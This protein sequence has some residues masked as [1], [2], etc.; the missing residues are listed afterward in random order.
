MCS[1]KQKPNI[2][3][4]MAD[5]CI[6][7]L[8]GAYGHKVVKT[9]NLDKLVQ[10]GVRFDSAYTPCPICAPA[11]A[12]MMTGKYISNHK[13]TDNAAPLSCAEPTFCHYLNNE[14]YD[15]VLSGKMHF[16]GPDQLHGFAKRLVTN[17]Y[18]ADFEW[19]P[20]R[21]VLKDYAPVHANPI[22][23]DYVTA[24]VRQS[25]MQFEYDE[26]AQFRALQYIY[27]RRMQVGGTLQKPPKERDPKPFFLCVSFNHP[28]EP[29][30]PSQQLWDLYENEEIEIPEF[31]DNMEETYSTMD[32]WLN[33]FHGVHRV[34][35]K[36][37]EAL[38]NMR[39]AYYALV[40]YADKKVGELVKALE[41]SGL[42]DNTIIIFTSDHGDM[43][44]EKGMV[45]KR[46]LDWI[47]RNG[48]EDNWFLH[49][50]FWDVHWPYRTPDGFGN[51]FEDAPIPSWLTEE[52]RQKHWNEPGLKSAQD[53][54][55]FHTKF[56][57]YRKTPV[58]ASSMEEVRKMFDGYDTSIRYVDTHIGYILDTL[59]KQGIL[60]DTAVIVSADHGE[61]L[62]ELNIY[63]A[64]RFGDYMS[65]R[66]PLIV[67]W[68]GITTDKGMRIDKAFHYHFDFAATV[69]ELMGGTVPENWDGVSFADAFGK[70]EEKGRD[71]LVI[72]AGAGGLSRSIR[73]DNY[74]CIRLYHDCYQCLPEIMLFDVKNDPH[75]LRDL[76]DERPDLVGR[77]MILLD[78]WYGRMMHTATYPHDPFW[79]VIVEGG[80]QDSRGWIHGYIER[81]KETG[82]R[83]WVERIIEK[84]PR[85]YN[86]TKNISSVMKHAY[87][88]V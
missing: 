79:D 84:Y 60:E 33:T 63:A 1:S 34:D 51:P 44:G 83:Q 10:N 49:V 75:E 45:Q 7:F 21:E 86:P 30:H 42:R 73:F 17:M 66:L 20:S 52:I 82:R 67:R 88:K 61:D 29:L 55:D 18:F 16:I 69:I 81:L 71:Y 19:T 76:A 8:M 24:G 14:G 64:H 68:P 58:Q 28:H 6:P 77:A 74:F 36:D 31:P 59:D 13:A 11:R 78:R 9:P 2:L 27:S 72:S 22:A 87:I 23:I 12:S 38:R 48:K 3:L 25:S 56:P 46:S 65:S 80:P 47:K 70:G 50:N 4:I 39:R 40:S 85:E 41:N 5:Q 37:K 62:G 57:E 26:E 35:M 53:M 54:F 43:L 32:K 15:T